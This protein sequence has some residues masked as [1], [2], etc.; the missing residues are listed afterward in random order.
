MRLPTIFAAFFLVL[1]IM[2]AAFTNNFGLY[3]E[4]CLPDFVPSHFMFPII[5]SVVYILLGFSFGLVISKREKCTQALKNKAFKYFIAMLALNL[6]YSPLFF[7]CKLFF[8]GFLC[9]CAM[10]F[11][12]FFSVL[13]F[14][15]FNYVS[16]IIMTVYLFWLLYC[17]YLNLA[18]IFL[19]S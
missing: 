3:R 8:V 17:A 18:I 2:S 10:I 14:S 1:G 9:I 16:G 15:S 4:L 7:D 6:L 5:W 19:N 11:L 12:S 13:Y